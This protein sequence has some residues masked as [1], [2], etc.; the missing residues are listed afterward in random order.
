MADRVGILK[1][2]KLVLDE[3][4]EA[5]KSRFRKIRY[6]NEATETREKY[7]QELDGFF[8]LKV[9]VRGWG[10]EAVVSNYDDVTFERLRQTDG[11]VEAENDSMS[12]EEIFLAVAG[13]ETKET[14]EA[15]EKVR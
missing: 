6:A 12:L 11:V 10:V 2:G 4:L 8:A 7:G 15:K 13:E 1:D 5:I 14:N 9:K 3:S